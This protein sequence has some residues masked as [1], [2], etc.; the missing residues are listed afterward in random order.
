VSN[1]QLSHHFCIE[2]LTLFKITNSK[3]SFAALGFV[4]YEFGELFIV[5]SQLHNQSPKRPKQAGTH[6]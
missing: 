5:Q 4:H 2:T 1:E 6:V 3:T